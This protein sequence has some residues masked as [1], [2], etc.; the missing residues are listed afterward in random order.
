MPINF[1]ETVYLRKV[2]LKKVEQQTH[3]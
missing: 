2:R 3:Q 1:L